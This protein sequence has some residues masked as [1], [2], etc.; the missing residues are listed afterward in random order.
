[1]AIRVQEP[2]QPRR[3]VEAS[4]LLIPLLDPMVGAAGFQEPRQPHRPV[5]ANI[6]LIPLLDPMSQGSPHVEGARRLSGNIFVKNVVDYGESEP[7]MDR[8]EAS[9]DGGSSLPY[10]ASL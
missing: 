9:V 8:L 2:E 7:A 1:V 5:E 4:I 6:L 3:P 10:Y